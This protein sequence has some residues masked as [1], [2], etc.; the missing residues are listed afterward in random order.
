MQDQA[1]QQ[2]VSVFVRYLGT[3]ACF[4]NGSDGFLMVDRDE[5]SEKERAACER[6]GD[7]VEM[8]AAVYAGVRWS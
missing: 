4:T 5:L 3:R 1:Q 6:G 7:T 8:S 2:T